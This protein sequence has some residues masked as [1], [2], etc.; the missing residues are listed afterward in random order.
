MMMIMIIPFCFKFRQA[1]PVT[2]ISQLP[3]FL[4][5]TLT[6]LDKCDPHTAC[7]FGLN[8]SD[9]IKKRLGLG[10]RRGNSIFAQVSS[11][12][13]RRSELLEV[14]HRVVGSDTDVSV[15][16]FGTCGIVREHALFSKDMFP[17]I[18]HT[19]RNRRGLACHRHGEPIQ[20]PTVT[21]PKVSS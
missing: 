6:S 3:P 15:D 11:Y 21:P 18:P 13:Y 4:P 20:L 14:A 7:P 16:H 17:P 8:G 2:G 12:S 5:P 9:I 19:S 10:G 1:N